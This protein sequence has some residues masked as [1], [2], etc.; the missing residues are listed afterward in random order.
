MTRDKKSLHLSGL[1]VVPSFVFHVA[2]LLPIITF[3][4]IPILMVTLAVNKIANLFSKKPREQNS[5][6]DDTIANVAIVPT[7]QRPFD[8]IMYGATGFTGKLAAM[9]IA[10]TYG[11]TSFRWAISGRR[12][13]ALESIRTELLALHPSIK[14]D[15]IA[16]VVAD[17]TDYPSLCKMVASTRVVCTTAGPFDKYGSDLVKCCAEQGT[18]YCDITG[19][20]DW[21]RI[22][23]H[24]AALISF[25]R[26]WL[27]YYTIL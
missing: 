20:T 14:E 22:M 5:D 7:K 21:V 8:L 6:S 25:S 24:T 19:E 16:I 10:K 9:Y 13:A 2:V 12:E 3:F 18:H 17:S 4:L 26:L 27:H 23:I 11:G 15:Q 1:K